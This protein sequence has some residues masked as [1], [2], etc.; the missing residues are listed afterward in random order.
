[1]DDAFRVYSAAMMGALGPGWW[2]SWPLSTRHSV[3]DV[4]SVTGGQL[5]RA[6]SLGALGVNSATHASSYRDHLSYNSNGSVEVTFKASGTT[7]PL[8]QAL[9]EAEIGAHVAFSRDR[10]VFAVFTGLRESAMTE[11][12]L[13]ARQ[14]TELYFRQEWE[15]GWM[16]VTH[17]LTA[18]AGTVLIAA[19]TTA[20]AEL[21]VTAA[22]GAGAA[23]KMADLAGKVGLAPEPQHRTRVAGRQEEHAV[24]PGGRATQVLAGPGGRGLRA[25]AAGQG[26]RP[27]RY[28]GQADQTGGEPARRG[29]RR[30]PGRRSLV[31]PVV[32]RAGYRHEHA[33]PA[34]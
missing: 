31:R 25:A 2:S 12:H 11:P 24:L 21:R 3:G 1:M 16:A 17:V 22:L 4:C 34:G 13:L 7:G 20:E 10:S 18:D 29:D 14:L 26:L 28:P 6:G 8:F 15:P 27:G 32:T 30:G 33:V 23:V 19:A 5:L 9:S